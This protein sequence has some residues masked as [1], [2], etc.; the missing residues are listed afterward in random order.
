MKHKPVIGVIQQVNVGMR[1][2]EIG[3]ANK[4]TKKIENVGRA[5]AIDMICRER[6]E[7]TKFSMLLGNWIRVTVC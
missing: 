7:I 6:I 4:Q 1:E 3:L 5:D 2:V